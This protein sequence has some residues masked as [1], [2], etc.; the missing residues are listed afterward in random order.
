VNWS[1]IVWKRGKE[2]GGVADAVSG[3]RHGFVYLWMFIIW[4]VENC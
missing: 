1:S 4:E 3:H 2:H